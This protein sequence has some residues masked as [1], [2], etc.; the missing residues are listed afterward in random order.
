MKAEHIAASYGVKA[1]VRIDTGEG[2]GVLV[3]DAPTTRW[4]SS[5]H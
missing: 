2:Y 3:N 4:R 5:M 1:H